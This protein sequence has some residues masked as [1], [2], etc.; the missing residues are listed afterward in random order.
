MANSMSSVFDKTTQ[1]NLLPHSVDSRS[2]ATHGVIYLPTQ[3]ENT[4]KRKGA[5]MIIQPQDAPLFII[6]GIAAF[7][8]FGEIWDSRRERLARRVRRCE[9]HRAA[10]MV[11]EHHHAADAGKCR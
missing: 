5:N 10:M 7:F 4:P 3:Q 2:H 9:H 1:K 11:V 6:Y 8:M